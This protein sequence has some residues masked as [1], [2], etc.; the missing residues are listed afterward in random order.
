M[1]NVAGGGT[2]SDNLNQAPSTHRDL[3][4]NLTPASL[5][6]PFA[7][8]FPAP[9]RSGPAA[10]ATNQVPERDGKGARGDPLDCPA[11]LCGNHLG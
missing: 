5:L 1:G 2:N 10:S 9:S 4:G 6:L 11:W 3:R 8:A 7:F